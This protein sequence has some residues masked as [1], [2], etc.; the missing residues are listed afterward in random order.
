MSTDDG[1]ATGR[2]SVG[3][4]AVSM[5]RHP[6]RVVVLTGGANTERNVS[7]SSGHAVAHALRS[8][9]HA[10]ALVDTAEPR[11]VSLPPEAAFTTGALPADDV[12][13]TPQSET[14]SPPPD[15]AARS[16]LRAGQRDG[17]LADGWDEVIAAGDVVFVTVFG[18]EGESGATQR[19]LQ[20]LGAVFTGPDPEVCA[21]TFDKARTKAAL[22]AHGVETPPWHVVHAG[23]QPDDLRALDV[24][25]PWIV[26][27]VAG[28]STIGLSYVDDPADL[29]GAVSRAV[30]DGGDALVEAYVDGRDLTVGALGDDV[31]AVVEAVTD[32]PLYDYTAKYTPGASAKRVPAALDDE[33][34][35]EVRAVTGRVHTL[36]GVGDTSSRSDFRLLTGGEITF[37]EVNP[38][39]GLT[40]TSSYPL[41]V[42]GAGIDFPRLCEELVVRALRRAGTDV[43]TVP[44]EENP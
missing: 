29:A 21:V 9:G 12:A 7:L 31:Y 14:A 43:I 40:P 27:P 20:R 11:E 44:R 6:L 5:L 32:R 42:A 25:G 39:P 38:L 3:H 18:D 19:Y 37:L 36:L 4:H 34:T 10:V 15:P 1:G 22:A 8:L 13:V 30:A 33:V 23:T 2:R 28:G 16:R 24:E 17:V 35:A 41:S 26:K